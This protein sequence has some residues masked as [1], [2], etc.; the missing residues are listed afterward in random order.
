MPQHPCLPP[1]VRP[2]LSETLKPYRHWA[3]WALL[4][5]P[6]LVWAPT[7]AGGERGALFGLLSP[8]GLLAAALLTAT[9]LA[10]PLNRVLPGWKGPRALRRNRRYF[11][12][13][14]FGYGALHLLAYALARGDLG[15]VLESLP[16]TRMWTGWAAILV[17]AALAATSNGAA[18]RRMGV[19]RWRRLQKGAHLAAALV[20]LHW[21]APG[22]WSGLGPALALFGPLA[23]MQALRLRAEARMRRARGR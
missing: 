18:M 1:G 3:L 9:L 19:A 2:G 11:G 10:T 17:M 12:L 16:R 23:A 22:G 8:T 20:F 15:W 21:A 7:L 13:A 14:A 5:A 4:A 6:A